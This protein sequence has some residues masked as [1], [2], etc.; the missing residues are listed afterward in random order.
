MNSTPTLSQDFLNTFSNA[1]NVAI[2]EFFKDSDL[3]FDNE[4][5]NLI[6]KFTNLI[7]NRKVWSK[8]KKCIFIG[9][10][11]PS[12]QRSHTIQK[13]ASIQII[14]ENNHTFKPFYNHKT[15]SLSIQK[16][17]NNDAS[18]FPGF[19][20]NHENL[21]KDYELK[22]DLSDAQD[23]M[24][25]VYRTICREIVVKQIIVQQYELTKQRY[26]EFRN[27]KVKDLICSKL[28]Q[29]FFSDNKL[30]PLNFKFQNNDKRLLYV[31]KEFDKVNKDLKGFLYVLHKAAIRSMLDDRKLL[32]LLS[33]VILTLDVVIPV[34]L[35]GRGNFSVRKKVGKKYIIKNIDV[36]LNVLP[37]SNNTKI[38]ISSLKKNQ[39]DIECYLA[40]FNNPLDTVN[41]IES[42]MVYGSDH[43][44][45]KPSV[46]DKIKP[47]Y[48]KKILKDIASTSGNIAQK[49]PITIFNDLKRFIINE[50]KSTNKIVGILTELLREESLKFTDL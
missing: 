33:I 43:W 22:K 38:I 25:Q 1:I 12:I 7:E 37:F 30:T 21:F 8:S 32:L 47:E 5:D 11:N 9:C 28:P 3:I 45:I 19:C 15:E 13:S 23:F 34:T 41:M 29:S 36:I 27:D 4:K 18:T 49:Y 14:S 46:W 31:N 24:L 6:L 42:W 39:K 17:G 50:I 48:Q 10:D 2:K 35:A 16:I 20:S 40:N 44:F 26:L